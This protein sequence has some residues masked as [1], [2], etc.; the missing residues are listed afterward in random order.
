M[1]L[2]ESVYYI[3]ALLIYRFQSCKKSSID[4]SNYRVVVDG[5]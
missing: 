1:R 5:A 3:S 2:A 4:E